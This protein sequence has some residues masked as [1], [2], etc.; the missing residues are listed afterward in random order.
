MEQSG[1]DVMKVDLVRRKRHTMFPVGVLVHAF[2]SVLLVLDKNEC[3][4]RWSF[5]SV[6]SV[7]SGL[8]VTIVDGIQFRFLHSALLVCSGLYTLTGSRNRIENTCIIAISLELCVSDI[9]MTFTK[10]MTK[11]H[12]VCV[13]VF[14][15][16]T[17]SALCTCVYAYMH[18]SDLITLEGLSLGF[19]L[20]VY[21]LLLLHVE[22]EL[23][24]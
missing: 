19:L 2:M 21:D 1:S 20:L 15:I 8:C 24:I 17:I 18:R 6:G 13:V 7:I 23:T 11:I 10:K 3:H 12:M 4:F 5:F 16:Y 22:F 9:F 14:Y